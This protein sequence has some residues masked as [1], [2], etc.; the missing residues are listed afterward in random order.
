MSVT[1]TSPKLLVTTRNYCRACSCAIVRMMVIWS[2]EGL[3]PSVQVWIVGPLCLTRPPEHSPKVEGVVVLGDT[4]GREES[5]IIVHK[6]ELYVMAN[7]GFTPCRHQIDQLFCRVLRH[8]NTGNYT[9]NH[10]LGTCFSVKVPVSTAFFH[11]SVAKCNDPGHLIKF[12][13]IPYSSHSKAPISQAVNSYRHHDTKA[14]H[15]SNPY[16]IMN[17]I[18][19]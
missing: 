19:L 9:H 17:V 1:T 12:L 4:W 5:P 14:G 18:L 7:G 13:Y 16:P 6:Q 8:P 3:E 2:L 10:L 11:V 15:N